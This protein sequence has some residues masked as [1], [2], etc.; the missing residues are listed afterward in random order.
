LER[1]CRYRYPGTQTH[2]RLR[3]IKEN[4]RHAYQ[5]NY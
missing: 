4:N 5:K 2:A 1:A 3:A